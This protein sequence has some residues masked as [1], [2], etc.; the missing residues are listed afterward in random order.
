[1]LIHLDSFS[2]LNHIQVYCGLLRILKE[3]N[4]HFMEQ[5]TI[6]QKNIWHQVES[7]LMEEQNY[8]PQMIDLVNKHIKFLF[9]I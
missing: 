8:R 7:K 3:M 9:W 6:S 4:L 1:M 5:E 2:Y